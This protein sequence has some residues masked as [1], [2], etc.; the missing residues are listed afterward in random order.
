MKKAKK[1]VDIYKKRKRI[2]TLLRVIKPIVFWGLL[3]ACV[4]FIVLAVRNSFGNIAEIKSL[5]DSKKFSGEQLQA[6]YT[7]LIEKYGEWVIGSGNNGFII[8]FINI[9]K[10]VFNGFM[11][12]Y[13]I[14]GVASGVLSVLLGKWILPML[15]NKFTQDNQ[16]M[17]NLAILSEIDNKNSEN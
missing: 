1:K 6:N 11:I 4:F 17:T 9:G 8:K 7:M 2:A 5:L 16:D 10:A 15:A 14:L 13:S 3:T 12:T